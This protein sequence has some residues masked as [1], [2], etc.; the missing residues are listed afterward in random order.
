MH[1]LSLL[2]GFLAPAAHAISPEEVLNIISTV[3]GTLPGI[4]AFSGGGE[5]GIA[6]QGG[7][8][9]IMASIALQ[10][11]PYLSYAAFFMLIYA[12]YRMVVG[13]DDNAK[14]QA[15]MVLNLSLAGLILAYI[16][17]PILLAFYGQQ[18]QVFTTGTCEGV[19][20]LNSKIME[21]IN[22]SLTIL[23]LA[24]VISII[25]TGLK[26]LYNFTSDEGVTE[27]RKAIIS[28]GMGIGII[29]LRFTLSATFTGN[30]LC[31]IGASPFISASPLIGK[32]VGIVQ[33]FLLFIG[34]AAVAVVIYAGILYLTSFGNEGQAEKGKGLLIRS[35]LG[36]V[37]ILL[38]YALVRFV[39]GAVA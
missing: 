5:D 35:L 30:M 8:G 25:I 28:I 24:A 38:S 10:L 21:I 15:K 23:A 9:S 20:T 39:I 34:L 37:V 7:F 31:P 13:Q 36:L 1:T 29:A 33:D 26:A 2:I 32:M 17:G 14:E 18:G 22:W 27:I 4:A 12:G 19:T 16:I 3:G 11:R 6:W